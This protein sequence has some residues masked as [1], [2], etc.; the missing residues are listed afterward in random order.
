MDLQTVGQEEEA[1]DPAMKKIAELE[2]KLNNRD[3]TAQQQRVV[4][5]RKHVDSIANEKDANG[6]LVRPRFDELKPVIAKLMSSRMASNVAEAYEKAEKL[7]TSKTPP[8]TPNADA[9]TNKANQVKKAKRAKQA[10]V[11]VKSS[12]SK[13]KANADLSL[14]GEIAN[15]I[16]NNKVKF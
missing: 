6:E 4:Q 11:G 1:T 8:P 5:F 2:T 15:A 7:T 10:A 3:E 9:Q 14:R 13:S 16:G 12:T